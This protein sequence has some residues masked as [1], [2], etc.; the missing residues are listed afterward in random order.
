MSDLIVSLYPSESAAREAAADFRKDFPDA[1]IKYLKASR[2]LVNDH[3]NDGRQK[4]IADEC[5][6][7]VFTESES[8][9]DAPE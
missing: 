1:F 5:W 6:A 2:V 3:L 9:F 7:V 8:V 4:E